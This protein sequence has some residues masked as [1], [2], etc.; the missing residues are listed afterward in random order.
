MKIKQNHLLKDLSGLSSKS[1][2][3][4]GIGRGSSSLSG[5][6]KIKNK[7]FIFL[8]ALLLIPLRADAFP[9]YLEIFN[10]DK[11]ARPEMKNMCSV[12]HINP[13]GGGPINDFG[14][15]FDANGHKITNNL[16]QKFPELFNLMKTLEPRIIRIK[17]TLITISQ[18][19]KI[20]IVGN[21]FTNDSTIKIDDSSEN[22]QATFV[23]PKDIDVTITF[24]ETGIHTVQVVNITGQVS[25]TF[26]V[27]VKPAKWYII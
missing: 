15:A 14:K 27:K 11:F 26:K 20:M 5:V 23:N 3:G 12:C 1:D 19:V 17:P 22:I 4:K 9:Q 21:N 10:N 16:R 18:E 6:Y 2:R 25:N 7:I 8:L 13:N 24:T